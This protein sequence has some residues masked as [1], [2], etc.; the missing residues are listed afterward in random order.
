MVDVVEYGERVDIE[1]KEGAIEDEDKRARGVM[2]KDRIHKRDN[3]G[4][5]P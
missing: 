1:D 3:R 2:E 5:K 4:N